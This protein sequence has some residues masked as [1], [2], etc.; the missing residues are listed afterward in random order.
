[1]AAIYV[2]PATGNDAN[3]GTSA[4]APVRSLTRAQALWQALP[5]TL[6]EDIDVWLFGDTFETEAPLSMSVLDD[7]APDRFLRFRPYG[8]TRPKFKAS[9]PLQG[10]T[11]RNDGLWSVMLPS[12]AAPPA[13]LRYGLT[14]MRPAFFK[15]ATDQRVVSWDEVNF[16]VTIPRASFDA[17]A[18]GDTPYVRLPM[19]WCV[20]IAKVASWA[21]SGPNVVL[22]LDPGASVLE[23]AKGTPSASHAG[24]ARVYLS[25]IHIS[26]GIVR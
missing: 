7:A 18:V 11:I 25:L 16:T 20:T 8:S 13:F 4:S 6:D 21:F 3:G 10:W 12:G 15:S 26:Q 24:L 17:L 23:F 9:V 22:T 1:M 14:T 19:G 5:T 2:S